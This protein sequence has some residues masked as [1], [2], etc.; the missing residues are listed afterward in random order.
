MVANFPCGTNRPLYLI[1]LFQYLRV[2]LTSRLGHA[3]CLTTNQNKVQLEVRLKHII[4]NTNFPRLKGVLN[5]WIFIMFLNFTTNRYPLINENITEQRY[6]LLLKLNFIKF[7]LQF[8][9]IICM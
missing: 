2:C 4:K 5:F 6:S 8:A 7:S 9:C 3:P 1:I